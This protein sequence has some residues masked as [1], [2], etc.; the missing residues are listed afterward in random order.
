MSAIA[1]ANHL[2]NGE[3][4]QARKLEA[5]GR[6]RVVPHS[7]ANTF[8]PQDA[9][10]PSGVGWGSTE[11]LASRVVAKRLVLKRIGLPLTFIP[12][13]GHSKCAPSPPV[14]QGPGVASGIRRTEGAHPRKGRGAMHRV[15]RG[16]I[17]R[18]YIYITKLMCI[19]FLCRSFL[20]KD[21]L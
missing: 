7:P 9:A 20:E 10:P 8:G 2:I 4:R 17:S 12:A 6:D 11:E 1:G 19:V 18:V 14:V 3:R 5:L 21:Y 13:K 16:E 15:G